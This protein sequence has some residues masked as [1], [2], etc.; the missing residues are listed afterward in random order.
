MNENSSQ[1]F[2]VEIGY[3]RCSHVLPLSVERKR[4][5]PPTNAQTTLA[6]GALSRTSV[7]SV[8]IALSAVGEAIG[9]AMRAPLTGPR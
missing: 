9:E 7:A 1:P 5:F 2:G 4:S 3:D 8:N 6:D